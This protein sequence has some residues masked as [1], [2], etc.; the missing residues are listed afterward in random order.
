MSRLTVLS[1][2]SEVFPLVKTGGLADVA[3][4]LPRA[5]APEGVDMTTLVPG[6]PAVMRALE[7]GGSVLAVADLFGGP[8][9]VLSGTAE[10][11]ALLVVDA[12][13]LFDRPGNPYVG[14]DGRDW[15]DNP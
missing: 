5:L 11:L 13:H 15:P 10:G 8:A 4:A 3:G 1:V 2:A 9:R 12:P 7:H 6:Y 14:P